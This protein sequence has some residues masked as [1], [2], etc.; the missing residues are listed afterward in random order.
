MPPENQEIRDRPTTARALWA[1]EQPQALG[2]VN[3]LAAVHED[4]QVQAGID[5]GVVVLI[6]H[7]YRNCRS[8]I[9]WQEVKAALVSIFTEKLPKQLPDGIL[10][11]TNK[12]GCAL[13]GDDVTKG[14]ILPRHM[15]ILMERYGLADGMQ[16]SSRQVAQIHGVQATAMDWP[17]K[18]SLLALRLNPRLRGLVL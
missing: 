1:L 4:P 7:M 3:Q 14:I 6:S 13:M 16:R 10:M 11:M 17:I 5:K 12:R 8:N 15:I 9:N 2:M 18:K